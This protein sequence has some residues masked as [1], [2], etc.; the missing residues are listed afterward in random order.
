MKKVI[1]LILAVVLTLSLATTAFADDSI[2]LKMS[3]DKSE[4]AVGD[5]VTITYSVNSVVSGINGVE[6]YTYY[7]PI[8]FEL[9][10]KTVGTSYTG[11]ELK[12]AEKEQVMTKGVYAGY[13]KIKLLTNND[14]GSFEVGTVATLIFRAKADITEDVDL[15]F[16]GYMSAY[17]AS[18]NPK[19]LGYGVPSD[20][21]NAPI[22][23]KAAPSSDPEPTDAA[24][25]VAMAADLSAAKAETV[26]IPVTVSSDNATKYN[27]V[28]MQFSYDKTALQLTSTNIDGYTV[29]AG[30]GTVR[31]Q[32]YGADKE[33]GSAAFT[34]TFK[35]IGTAESTVTLTSAK[36]DASAHA[37]GNDAPEAAMTDA[38]TKVTI[39]G[40]TVNL[41][42][43]FN[44]DTLVTEGENYVFTAK[45]TNYNYTVTATLD[46]GTVVEVTDNGDGT[47]TIPEVTGNVTITATKDG[48][49][50]TVTINGSDTTGATS[51]K[52]GENYVFTMNKQAGYNYALTVKIGGVEYT[53]YTVAEDRTVTIPGTAITGPVEVTVDKTEKPVAK[54]SVEFTGA[55]G[56]VK[57]QVSEVN[58]GETYSFEVYDRVGYIYEITAT[59]GGNP[60]NVTAGDVSSGYRT[61]TVDEPV[62][63]NLVIN[64]S[65]VLDA[66]VKVTEYVN[67]D[68]K[69]V[70]MIAASES[71]GRRMKYDGNEMYPTNNY[72]DMLDVTNNV[73]VYLVIVDKGETISEADV[74][75]KLSIATTPVNAMVQLTKDVNGTE[76]IDINDAQLTYDIYNG[77][78]GDF[79]TVNMVQFL[80]ADT[81]GDMKVDVTDAV[82]ILADIA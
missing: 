65:R 58:E 38:D 63:G 66:T 16:M 7:D 82:A 6:I 10:G 15:K 12:F 27:A 77:K 28:D 50:Q 20:V 32:G 47:F 44:G 59:M 45:D 11:N 24:Y 19:E 51:A 8:Y 64:I 78:Y 21:Y 17:D 49:P 73:F 1:A 54:Y 4:V 60:V 26:S 80:N 75:K 53:D 81:N 40:L 56:D 61:Y 68:G 18:Y 57:E 33:C 52:Y 48:K 43:D 5:T 55:G 2:I 14:P 39:T 35:V 30:D 41:S 71:K 3:L 37:I 67:T 31:V 79:D 9:V 70:F 29:T 22:T 76:V 23:I 25:S 69:T 46:D 62:T 42:D 34:L 36:V 74:L 13:N 72:K